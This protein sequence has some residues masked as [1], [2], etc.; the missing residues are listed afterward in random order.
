[1]LAFL[2]AYSPELNPDEQVWIH[3]KTDIGKLTKKSKDDMEKK[4]LSAKLLTTQNKVDL[5]KSFFQL[6][7]MPYAKL[8][9]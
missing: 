2:P 9:I 5:V 1:M 6:P 7:D 8:P 3:A 4:V